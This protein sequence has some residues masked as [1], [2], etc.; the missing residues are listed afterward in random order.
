MRAAGD[1]ADEEDGAGVGEIDPDDK[2]FTEAGAGETKLGWF[3]GVFTP[4]LLNIFGVIMFLRLS[5]VAGQ[6]GLLLGTVIITLSNIVTGKERKRYCSNSIRM[7][8]FC[9]ML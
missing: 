3:D 9:T 2:Q 8:L 7:C 5:F 6:A 4:C 1:N